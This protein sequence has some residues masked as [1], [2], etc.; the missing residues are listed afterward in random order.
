MVE[1]GSISGWIKCY[2]SADNI[3]YI[4]GY[5]LRAY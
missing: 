4:N 2:I 1:E 5:Q 3:I